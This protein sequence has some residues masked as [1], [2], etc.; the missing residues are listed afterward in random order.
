MTLKDG[1][2]FTKPKAVKRDIT[3][4]KNRN[5]FGFHSSPLY[6]F[7]GRKVPARMLCTAP[8]IKVIAILRNPIDRLYSHYHFI[9]PEKTQ[10]EDTPSFEEFVNEDIALLTRQGVLK[11]WNTTN[12]ESY[13]SSAAECAAWERYVSIAKGGGPVGRGLYAIQLEVWMDEFRKYNKSISDDLLI[14]QSE[15]SK[16][17]PQDSYHQAVQFFGL[18]P[19]TTRKHK[20]VLGKNHHATD[21]SGSDGLSE[22]MYRRLYDLYRPYNERLYDLLGRE[23]WSGVWDDSSRKIGN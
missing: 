17:Y 10:T 20:H 19:R 21:Y 3:S 4:P 11:D 15:S 12:F 1:K 13:S 18:E 2:G 5:K 22:E 7:S 16:L 6:L 14:L 23:E 8:W 9:H